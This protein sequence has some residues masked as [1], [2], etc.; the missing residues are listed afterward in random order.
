FSK[1]PQT[2]DAGNSLSPEFDALWKQYVSAIRD[3]D[4]ERIKNGRANIQKEIPHPAP[5]YFKRFK[6]LAE[7]DN[8]DAQCWILENLNLV[9]SDKAEQARTCREMF[10]LLIP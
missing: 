3:R 10:A 9:A 4:D 5:L 7:K 1:P 2:D 8:A 6:A